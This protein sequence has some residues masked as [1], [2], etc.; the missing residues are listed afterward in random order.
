MYGLPRALDLSF[1]KGARLLQACIG[2]NELILNFDQ[3]ISI[4]IE[5]TF[6]ILSKNGK[7]RVF[8][9]PP[10]AA[11]PLVEL[12]DSVVTSSSGETEGTLTLSFSN[13]TVLEVFDSSKQFESYQIRH[14]EH[15]YVV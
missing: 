3:E 7:D 4:T 14:G 2:A 11:E 6:R 8:S 15:Q 10:L 13:G 1:F 9:R 5:S 12:L